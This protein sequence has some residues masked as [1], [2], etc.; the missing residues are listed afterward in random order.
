M[1]RITTTATTATITTSGETTT[2]GA[3]H[4]G[5]PVVS[6]PVDSPSPAVVGKVY[7]TTVRAE[8]HEHRAAVVYGLAALILSIGVIIGLPLRHRDIA[9]S[10]ECGG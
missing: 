7:H 3:S 5:G 6:P 8:L 1:N 4:H 10:S 9:T 2:A